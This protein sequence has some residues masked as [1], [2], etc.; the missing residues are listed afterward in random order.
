VW[1]PAARCRSRQRPVVS[2]RPLSGQ[3][4][5][6]KLFGLDSRKRPFGQ[7]VKDISCAA[8]S[9]SHTSP[10][11]VRDQA[12]GQGCILSAS[13]INLPPTNVFTTFASRILTGS[14]AKMSSLTITMSASLPG[15]IEP[16]SFS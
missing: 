11:P 4:Q 15:V 7:A 2:E 16:F 5:P 12:G 9:D 3:K 1:L 8:G 6:L 13:Q 14:I 10:L